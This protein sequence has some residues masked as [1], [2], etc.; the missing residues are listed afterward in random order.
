MKLFKSQATIALEERVQELE[1]ENTDLRGQL[2]IAKQTAETDQAVALTDATE[3][4]NKLTEANAAIPE[5]ESKIT[6]L[7]TKVTELEASNVITA[8][9]IDTAAAQKLASMGHGEPLD[10]GAKAPTETS[11]KEL[12]LVAFNELTPSQRMD[13]I[14]SG[15][16]ISN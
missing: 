2:E 8:E 13:F 6:V 10:L 11:A 7:E 15:G 5:L 9:K 16:K 4:I 3:Q 12:S 1:T 14:K